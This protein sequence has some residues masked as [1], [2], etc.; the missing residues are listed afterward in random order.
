MHCNEDCL[1]N[2]WPPNVQLAQRSIE[3]TDRNINE[4]LL[5]DTYGAPCSENSKK[6][7][8]W[9]RKLPSQCK[10]WI[11]ITFP[12]TTS[13]PIRTSSLGWT[14]KI[15]PL[16]HRVIWWAFYWL[17]IRVCRGAKVT[18]QNINDTWRQQVSSA[19]KLIPAGWRVRVA[20]PYSGP[21]IFIVARSADVH[22]FSEPHNMTCW[23]WIPEE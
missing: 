8:S 21:S 18:K 12:P 1:V 7:T 10:D 13:R 2:I 11:S 6:F 22:H 23:L 16:H 4:M 9:N 15:C 3:T 5:M 20:F 17:C 19:P 14:C